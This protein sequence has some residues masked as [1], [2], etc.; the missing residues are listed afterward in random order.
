MEFADAELAGK[1]CIYIERESRRPAV[2]LRIA[3]EAGTVQRSVEIFIRV[4]DLNERYEARRQQIGDAGSDRKFG[5]VAVIV[6]ARRIVEPVHSGIEGHLD[7]AE[8]VGVA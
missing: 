8:T 2:G 5:P 6:E 3:L 7:A 4:A 1:D